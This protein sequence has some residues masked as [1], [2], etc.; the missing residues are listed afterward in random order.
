MTRAKHDCQI[1]CPGKSCKCNLK[2]AEGV[3]WLPWFPLECAR[4]E[5]GTASYERGTNLD[6]GWE[7]GQIGRVG[8]AT[9]PLVPLLLDAIDK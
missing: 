3:A 4:P 2:K 7:G 6:E 1:C 9:R 5:E 8:Q